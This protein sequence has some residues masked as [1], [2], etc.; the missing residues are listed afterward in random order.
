MWLQLDCTLCTGTLRSPRLGSPSRACLQHFQ[1]RTKN[2]SPTTCSISADLPGHRGGCPQC[3]RMDTSC[4]GKQLLLVLLPSRKGSHYSCPHLQE[5]EPSRCS[6]SHW[7]KVAAFPVVT[8]CHV[9]LRLSK[10]VSRHETRACFELL[11]ADSI[12]KWSVCLNTCS[13]SSAAAFIINWF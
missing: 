10:E 5:E 12:W 6:R 13:T 11:R 4:L 7:D 3:H 8:Q 9:F 1:G 2:C